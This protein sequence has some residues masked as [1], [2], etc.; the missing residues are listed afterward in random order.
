MTEQ[1]TANDDH[2][3]D[4]ATLRRFADRDRPPAPWVYPVAGIG[5]GGA[6]ALAGILPLLWGFGLVALAVAAGLGYDRWLARSQGLPPLR[7]LPSVVRR[8]Q[9]TLVMGAAAVV[10]VPLV[11]AGVLG[12]VSLPAATAVAGVGIAVVLGVGGPIVDRR[13][14]SNARELLR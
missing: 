5:L 10:M 11:I 9:A 2:A 13:A 3:V 12:W 4:D 7:E 8:G 6:V 1:P 14:R